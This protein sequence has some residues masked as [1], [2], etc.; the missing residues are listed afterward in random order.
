MECIL[1][2]LN[3]KLRKTTGHSGN[4]KIC[5]K[6]KKFGCC[7]P[8]PAYVWNGCSLTEDRLAMHQLKIMINLTLRVTLTHKGGSK[9]IVQIATIVARIYLNAFLDVTT[10]KIIC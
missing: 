4:S 8:G 1:L 6:K 9:S 7:Q 5:K 3:R 10:Q 2:I